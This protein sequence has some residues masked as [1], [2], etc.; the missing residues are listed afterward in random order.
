MTDIVQTGI[1]PPTNNRLHKVLRPGYQLQLGSCCRDGRPITESWRY[2]EAK[3]LG[4]PLIQTEHEHHEIAPH[5]KKLL[6]D[7][8]T[9]TSINDI[10][11][12]ELSTQYQ[13][14]YTCVYT[15]TH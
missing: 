14:E 15:I 10:I 6:V 5:K 1:C 4:I 12:Y 8:Y 3:R 9:P 7:Q 2:K 13:Q 11:Q